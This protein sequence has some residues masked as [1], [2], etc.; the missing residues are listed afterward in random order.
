MN[1][2]RRLE[3]KAYELTMMRRPDWL[4]GLWS[5]IWFHWY[6]PRPIIENWT[7]RACV[8]DGKCGCNNRA[9]LELACVLSASKDQPT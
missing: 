7:A 2:R 9:R 1:I 3:R 4:V 6:C 5:L 8:R